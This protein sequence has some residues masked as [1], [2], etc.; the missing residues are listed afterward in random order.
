MDE[1]ANRIEQQEAKIAWDNAH[2]EED[3]E[4]YE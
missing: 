3:P 1:E 2:Q 4:F